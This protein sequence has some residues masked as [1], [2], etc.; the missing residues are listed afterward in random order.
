MVQEN[1]LGEISSSSPYNLTSDHQE[2]LDEVNSIRDDVDRVILNLHWGSE[3]MEQPSIQQT[4]IAEDLLSSGVDVIIGHHPH[5]LQPIEEKWRH[6][7][8]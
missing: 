1:Y 3:F 2:I 8:L 4:K 7:R 6:S 5:V